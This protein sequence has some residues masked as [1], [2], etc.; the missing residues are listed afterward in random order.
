MKKSFLQN[1]VSNLKHFREVK[2]AESVGIAQSQGPI[3][4][5]NY[6]IPLQSDARTA[7]E[8]TLELCRE[9]RPTG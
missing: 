9:K 1:A 8:M 7:S 6:V 4:Y 5:P 2:L 3:P